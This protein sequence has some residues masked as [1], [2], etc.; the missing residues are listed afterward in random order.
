MKDLRRPAEEF[1]LETPDGKTLRA[2]RWNPKEHSPPPPRAAVAL[3]HGL[4]EHARRYEHVAAFMNQAG[5]AVFSFDQ[6]GHGTSVESVRGKQGY[7]ESYDLMLDDIALLLRTTAE[8]FPQSPLV[9]YGHSMG[10]N[11]TLNYALRRGAS[12]CAGVIASSPALRTAA[13]PPRVKVL[14]GELLYRLAPSFRLPNG[15][16]ISGISRDA[17]VV[18][19]Y[20]AD[21][22]RHGL[23]SAQLG[24]DL[25]HSGAWALENASLLQKPLLLLHGEA[26][27]VTSPEAT[28]DF[29]A[30]APQRLVT[31]SLW[32]NSYHELHNEPDKHDVLS[33]MLAWIESLL[34]R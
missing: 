7:G 25:L 21:P 29:A 3:V 22:L 14:A 34:A 26:D 16:D 30:R 4:G 33:Q 9:L 12:E 5:F 8:A 15:L 17:D 1:L 10:G 6:R 18:A 23:L 2:Y 20:R 19:A 28:K 32:K 13:P 31:L 11:L 24:I 27:R